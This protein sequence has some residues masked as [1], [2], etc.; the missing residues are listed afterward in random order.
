[1]MHTSALPTGVHLCAWGRVDGGRG[2]AMDM[3]LGLPAASLRPLGLGDLPTD[4]VFPIPVRG[5]SAKPQVDLVRCACC[6]CSLP[7]I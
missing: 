7:G 3:T 6:L 4:Y 5:T 1:M 2:N